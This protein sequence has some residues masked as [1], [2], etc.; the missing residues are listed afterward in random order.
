MELSVRR[1][2]CPPPS[3]IVVTNPHALILLPGGK[4]Q[5]PANGSPALQLHARHRSP[6]IAAKAP[7]QPITFDAMIG[8]ICSTL[9]REVYELNTRGV[10]P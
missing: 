6:Q 8:E 7:D 10:T 2:T 1:P 3:H 5:L 9:V 4:D